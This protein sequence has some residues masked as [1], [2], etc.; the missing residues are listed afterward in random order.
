MFGTSTWWSWDGNE[1]AFLQKTSTRMPWMFSVLYSDTFIQKGNM[2]HTNAH[3]YRIIL[4]C[5]VATIGCRSRPGLNQL[6]GRIKIDVNSLYSVAVALGIRQCCT[7]RPCSV[8]QFYFSSFA[9][10]TAFRSTEM[11][12]RY[13]KCYNR[14]RFSHRRMEMKFQPF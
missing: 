12:L 4:C 13:R 14:R 5:C 8:Q 11:L 2:I 6:W 1:T 7:A 10:A 3:K 9:G